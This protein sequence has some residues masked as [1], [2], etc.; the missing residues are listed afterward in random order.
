MRRRKVEDD[1]RSKTRITEFF[2][3]LYVRV[4]ATLN[5]FRHILNIAERAL[6]KDTTSSR[7][8][9]DDKSPISL[10]V[11]EVLAFGSE[12]GESALQSKFL[13]I[14][15]AIAHYGL[16]ERPDSAA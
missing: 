16:P 2:E 7:Q 9:L 15:A 3:L 6:Q 14:E 5:A 13:T 8:A 11:D 10:T 12:R 4:Q 1:A